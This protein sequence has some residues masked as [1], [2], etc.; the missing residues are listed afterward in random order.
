[1]T[2]HPLRNDRG[3]SLLETLIAFT[4]LAVVLTAMVGV[5]IH[6]QRFYLVASDAANTMGTLQRLEDVVT[7]EFLPLNP[8]AG[9]IVYAAADSVATRAFRGVYWVCAKRM[10]TDAEI[11]VRSLTGGLAIPADS[12]L[13]YSNG[14]RATI[15]DDH[16]K[17]AEI[18]SVSSDVC[19]DSSQ[20]WTAV[21]P[22]LN[23]SLAE[24][25]VGAP[26]RAYQMAR[27]WLTTQDGS[28]YMKSDALGGSPSVVSGP[29]A[30]ADSTGSSVLSLKYTDRF[31]KTTAML[32]EIHKI[33]ID[34]SALGMVPTRRGGVPM[35]KNRA[36]AVKLRNAGQ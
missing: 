23:A 22:S 32:T 6:Q 11:T 10:V 20:G 33:E 7:P 4:L 30:P 15:A 19:P 18:T 12:A 9:D 25:P 16:W 35:N 36:L 27:Y 21:V 3:V 24:V 1:M 26:V 14:T 31:G 28:W 34:V 29:L 2:Q 5:L 17:R 8:A 13:V